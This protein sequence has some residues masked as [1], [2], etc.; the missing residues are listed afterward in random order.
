MPRPVN[1]RFLGSEIPPRV[2]KP[3]GVPARDL[4]VVTLGLDEAEAIRLADLEGLYQEAAARSMGVSRPTFGRIVESARRKVADAVLNGKALRVEG[5]E[6]CV[7]QEGERKMK[8]AVPSKGG[9][10]DE[11]FGHCEEFSLF[12]VEGG[13]VSGESVL[14]SGQGC[15]CKSGIAGELARLGVTHLVAG[16]MGEGAVRVLASNGI[17]VSRGASGKAR[18]AAEAFASGS[19]ADSGVGCAGH[20]EGHECS[21]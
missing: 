1:E 18:A 4:E 21:H 10:V 3:A 17:K 6:I 14:P 19:L 11:H 15:G 2:M 20:G 12:E 5:G 7:R 13:K 8:I 16:N 9:M